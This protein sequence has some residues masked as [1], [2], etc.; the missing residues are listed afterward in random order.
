[1]NSTHV[2]VETF[3]LRSA[4]IL[5]TFLTKVCLTTSSSFEYDDKDDAARCQMAIS[6]FSSEKKRKL[7]PNKKSLKP[8]LT[9][10]LPVVLRSEDH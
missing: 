9:Y 7:V 6:C 5:R 10:L 1:M 4:T 3:F 2:P 8:M